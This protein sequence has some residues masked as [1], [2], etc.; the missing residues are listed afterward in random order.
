MIYSSHFFSLCGDTDMRACYASPSIL[1]SFIILTLPMR[2]WPQ[3]ASGTITGVV[4]DS[5]GAVIPAASVTVTEQQTGTSVMVKAQADGSYTA[6]NLAPASYRVEAEVAGFKRLVIDGLKVD[7]GSVL[8]QDLVLEVGGT[9]ESIQVTGRTSLVETTS[10]AVG[11][12]V[13]IDQMLEMP[14]VHRDVFNL[15]T[16]V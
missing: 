6:P 8:T 14:Q 13:Q 15:R 9:T 1:I 3:F 16:L 2:L 12:T 4:K 7:V 11:T 5:T 10:G